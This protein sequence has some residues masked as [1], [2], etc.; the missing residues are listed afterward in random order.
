MT[1]QGLFAV[2]GK[3]AFAHLRAFTTSD[4]PKVLDYGGIDELHGRVSILES[5]TLIQYPDH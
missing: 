5:K 2:V 1:T 4:R 3:E